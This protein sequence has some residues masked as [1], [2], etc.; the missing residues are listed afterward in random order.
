LPRGGHLTVAS[1]G[2]L[3]ADGIYE[4]GATATRSLT[5]EAGATVTTRRY[6]PGSTSAV[7]GDS[8]WI[9]KWIADAS[10]VTTLNVTEDMRIRGGSMAVD[11]S[12]YDISNGTTLI[13]VDYGTL[14]DSFYAV[15]LTSGWT[16]D[17]DMAYDQGGGDLAIALII[18][19]APAPVVWDGEAGDALWATASNWSTDTVPGTDDTILIATNGTV[20]ALSGTMGNGKVLNLTSNAVL[21]GTSAY[22]ITSTC[23]FDV[24]SGSELTGDDFWDIRT[25]FMNFDAG[26]KCTI[27]TFELKD[28][29]TFTFNL[30]ADGFTTMMPGR[31][32]C[33]TDPANITWTVDMADY[34]GGL[35]QIITLMDFAT[36]DGNAY[37]M[38]DV[39]FQTG[40]L[41]VLNAVG[42]Y[43][44]STLSWDD[45]EFAVQLK[46]PSLPGTVILVY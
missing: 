34:A 5:I 20:T 38:T 23:T 35:G 19:S 9:T 3:T 21:Y 28:N 4:S 46:I 11:L 15:T 33:E 12:S 27:P 43:E 17:V 2:T 7:G 26:A 22:R 32:K 1:N 18:I 40:T 16:A 30:N 36:N 31:M 13:L 10:G 44:G 6:I 14:Y 37:D 24:G 25:C 29:P 39:L 41:N 42:P 8:G 45:A